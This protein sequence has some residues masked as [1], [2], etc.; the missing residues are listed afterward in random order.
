ML[1]FLSFTLDEVW[2]LDY[3]QTASMT[4]AVFAGML[5][6]SL[7]WGALSDMHGRR[8]VFLASSAVIAA[9]GTLSAF[10]INVYAMMF[11]RFFV[12]VG[13]GGFTIPFDIA[14]EVRRCDFSSVI[15][16]FAPNTH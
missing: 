15:F 3:W 14:A 12:G 9:S 5:I 7:I 1:S 4:S 11:C 8:P 6:G 2:D 13:V 10:A 16:L